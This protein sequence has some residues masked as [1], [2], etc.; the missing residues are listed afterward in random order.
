MEQEKAPETTVSLSD[1]EK[2]E[3]A[4]EYFTRYPNELQEL[5]LV[6]NTGPV[7][8][9]SFH[10]EELYTAEQWIKNHQDSEVGQQIPPKSFL[11]RKDAFDAY[12]DCVL[13]DNDL[14][15]GDIKYLHV[16]LARKTENI[17]D[18]TLVLAPVVV[19]ANVG[20]HVYKIQDDK[21]F[22]MEHLSPCPDCSD[23]MIIVKEEI[24]K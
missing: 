6:S 12:M 15:A 24:T 7:T 23:S 16:F 4:L 21:K 3:I 14:R 13:K 18:T 8:E 20:R 11:L 17:A 2:K 10:D 9:R 19:D 1:A 5:L 22:V